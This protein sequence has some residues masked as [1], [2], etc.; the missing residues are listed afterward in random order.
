MS[1]LTNNEFK[2]SIF[3]GNLDVINYPKN[4]VDLGLFKVD[5]INN[6]I[7][8]GK[9]DS[10]STIYLYGNIISNLTVDSW[11]GLLIDGYIN[12]FATTTSNYLNQYSNVTNSYLN[13]FSL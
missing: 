9:N 7:Y 1:S 11:Y 8:I 12:Q 2:T 5:T 6:T 13:Q 10:S 3:Y 4:V